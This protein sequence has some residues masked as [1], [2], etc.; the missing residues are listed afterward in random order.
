MQETPNLRWLALGALAGLVAAGYGML[1]QSPDADALPDEAV[2]RINDT[3][4]TATVLER[5][6]GRA[7][8]SDGT[9]PE[10]EWILEQL[11]NEELL[12]QR[13]IELGMAQSDLSVRNALVGSLVASVTAEAD[14]ANPDDATLQQF[15]DDNAERYRYTAAVAVEAWVSDDERV[16]QAFIAALE[17]S[18]GA[19]AVDGMEPLQDMPTSLLPVEAL[20][21]HVGPGI[22]AAAADMPDGA[23]AIFARRGRWLV[24]RVNDR[25]FATESDLASIRNRVLLDYR[26]HLADRALEAYLDD[27]R[28][29]AD[30]V[31]RKP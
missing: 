23:S 29:R 11:V 26:R 27:L 15:L 10:P 18:D 6:L 25:E 19:P 20:A 2:A 24:I 5:E 3:V 30:V 1:R 28:Q 22:A 8:G 13:G 17:K 9:P 14:A 21:D 12:V 31:V 16:A 7:T 4:I